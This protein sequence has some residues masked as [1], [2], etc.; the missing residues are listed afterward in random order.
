MARAG[1]VLGYAGLG[2]SLLVVLLVVSV[3]AIGSGR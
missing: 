1:L 2:L 3:I